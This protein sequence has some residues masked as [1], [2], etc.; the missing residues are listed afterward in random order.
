MRFLGAF[1]ACAALA[2]GV[3]GCASH[4][5]GPTR[6]IT[7]DEDVAWAK[8]LVN[9]DLSIFPTADPVTQARLRNEILTTRMYIADTEYHHYEARLTRE[10]QDEGL[11][12]TA[13]S[14]GLT[15]S[16]TLVPVAQTKTL[17]SALATGITGL[18]KAYNEKQLLSNTIQALQTQMRADR[19]AEAG[20]IYAKMFKNVGNN[21]R[22]ITPIIEYPLPMALSDMDAY[23]QAGTVSSAVIGLS[24]TVTTAE[25]N[26]DQVKSMNGPN[27]SE[28]SEAKAVAAPVVPPMIN[29][30]PTTI[31]DVN[32]PTPPG[33]KLSSP[34]LGSKGPVEKRLTTKAIKAFQ[35]ALCVEPDGKF[36]PNTRAAVSEYLKLLGRPDTSAE[37]NRSTPGLLQD[38]VDAVGSCAGRHYANVFEVV[39]FGMPTESMKKIRAVQ[40]DLNRILK[41][42][43]KPPIAVTGKFT[44]DSKDQDPTRNAIAE[45]RKLLRPDD[46]TVQD[47]TKSVNRALDP[48]FLS[49]IAR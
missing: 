46:Q 33:P 28:V 6:P 45:V 29:R 32:A 9:H 12:A 35:A 3:A 7:I 38:A 19:K 1:V 39:R 10:L 25:R 5:T 20:V 22:E 41:A 48:V 40:D 16:A 47:T 15:T 27:P 49:D 13:A 2:V 37:F 31:R 11:A 34:P 23:Y 14:L 17:L 8:K 36:G 30:R 21:V 26:A 4:Q 18:D 43:G 44:D 24:K 42:H